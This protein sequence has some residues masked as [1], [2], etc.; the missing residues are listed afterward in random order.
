MPIKKVKLKE[1]SNIIRIINI[2]LKYE[3]YIEIILLCK[4]MQGLL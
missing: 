2:I 3:E 1:N 4:I